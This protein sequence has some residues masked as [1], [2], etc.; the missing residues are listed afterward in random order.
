MD[1]IES[2][3]GPEDTQRWRCSDDPRLVLFLSLNPPSSS[4]SPPD[5]P[6]TVFFR[7]FCRFEALA[8]LKESQV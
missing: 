4:F 7:L 5:T 3:S 2:T 6:P 1:S 8:L